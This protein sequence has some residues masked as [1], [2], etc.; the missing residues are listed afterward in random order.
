MCSAYVYNKLFV[1]CH[2]SFSLQEVTYPAMHAL[3]GKWAP[4]LE[5]SRM[6]TMA[7]CGAYIGNVVAFPLSGLLC[8]CGF[9]GGWPSVFYLFGEGGV[10]HGHTQ[11]RTHTR[12]H[13]HTRMHTH[14]NTHMYTHTYV[15]AY[16]H[17]HKCTYTHTHTHIW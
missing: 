14:T 5:R 9:A 12:T 11:V 10:R 4:P 1:T 15:H 13:M 7:L 6:A 3:L 2:L 17:T 8:Q 16:T